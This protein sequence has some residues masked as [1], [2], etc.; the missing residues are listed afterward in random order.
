MSVVESDCVLGESVFMRNEYSIN[1][2]IEI[3]I[4]KTLIKIIESISLYRS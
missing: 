4:P 3:S 1:G 2:M